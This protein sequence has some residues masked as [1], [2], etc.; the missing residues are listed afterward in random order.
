VQRNFFPLRLRLQTSTTKTLL[1]TELRLSQGTDCELL[2]S[3]SHTK[4]RWAG[5][6][7]LKWAEIVKSVL[8]KMN[9]FC[10][11]LV[12]VTSSRLKV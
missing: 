10:P 8:A 3:V 6:A 7:A 9:V 2:K 12:I 11:C 4:R 5:R 1:F